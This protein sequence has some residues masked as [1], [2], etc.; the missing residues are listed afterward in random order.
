MNAYLYIEG[1]G[2]S[3]ELRT[4][5]REGFRRLLERCG[6]AGRMP[7]LVACGGRSAT[8]DDFKT[9]HRNA[10]EGDYVAMLADSEAPLRTRKGRGRI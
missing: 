10:A 3:K 5:C 8:F 1:G 4:R 9:A 2:N 6:F 7:R